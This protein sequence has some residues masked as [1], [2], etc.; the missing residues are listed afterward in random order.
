MSI[1][2]A[3]GKKPH[4]IIL[5][6]NILLNLLDPG[7][8]SDEV[9]YTLIAGSQ[10]FAEVIIPEQVLVEWNHLKDKT[11]D[12]HHSNIKKNTSNIIKLIKN[13]PNQLGKSEGQEAIAELD[14]MARRSYE[15]HYGSRKKFIDKFIRDYAII[16]KTR[17]SSIDS[18]IVDIALKNTEPFFGG[19]KNESTDAV[20]YFGI[21]EYMEE[22]R[23]EFEKVVF[24]SFNKNEFAKKGNPTE[25]NPL[26]KQHFEEFDIHFTNHLKLVYE[27]LNL[28][29]SKFQLAN[30]IAES[31]KDR[32]LNL[33][34][35]YFIECID[36]ECRNEVHIN[37]D[38]FVIGPKY[39]YRCR[40]CKVEW[41]S[42]D[43]IH[44]QY[45]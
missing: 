13:F 20:I 40:K 10:Q 7:N 37:I 38:T 18:K 9:F 12:I 4:A 21:L 1:L 30:I 16:I 19:T 36:K 14:K 39:F 6:T 26:L 11:I 5:D 17:S 43:T 41:D 32:E 22:H 27:Y 34:D 33:S 31:N 23:K 3:Y 28:D 42:G 44:D 29:R 2:R 45:N 35:D 15:Y 25:L 8:Y 24:V